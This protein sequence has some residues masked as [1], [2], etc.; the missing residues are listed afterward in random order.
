MSSGES[1]SSDEIKAAAACHRMNS[2]SKQ[3]KLRTM[4]DTL[5]QPIASAKFN[6][7]YFFIK[8]LLELSLF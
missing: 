5:G 7:V 6:V 1:I 4:I 3:K 8:V 2:V